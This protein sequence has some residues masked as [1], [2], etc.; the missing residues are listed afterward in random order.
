MAT[1]Y[2]LTDCGWSGEEYGIQEYDGMFIPQHLMNKIGIYSRD[3]MRHAIALHNA[4]QTYILKNG[5][6]KTLVRKVQ[7]E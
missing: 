6:P 7:Y 1:T 5:S 3:E 4:K 2:T